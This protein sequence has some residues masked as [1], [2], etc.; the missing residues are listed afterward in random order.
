VSQTST[1]CLNDICNFTV[2]SDAVEKRVTDHKALLL[3][4]KIKIPV[5]GSGYWKLNTTLLKEDDY[6]NGICSLVKHFEEDSNLETI[7]A[8]SKWDVLKLRTKEFSIKTGIIMAKRKRDEITEIEQEIFS[9]DKLKSPNDDLVL[10]KENLQNRLHVLYT[11][12]SQGA[13]IRARV[14]EEIEGE[15]NPKFFKSIEKSRQTRNVI[16]SLITD[17]NIEVNEQQEVLKVIGEF[18]EKLYS[19]NNVQQEEINQFLNTVPIDTILSAKQQN[20]LENMPS[21]R[22][23]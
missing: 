8:C 17:D 20:E 4:C 23:F 7:S 3:T 18:Y 15:C 2:I 6:C 16:E 22:K 5:R 21:K 10:R 19:S 1:L 14:N 12:V 11:N 9:I 13:Q